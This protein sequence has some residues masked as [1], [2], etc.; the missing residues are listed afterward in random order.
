MLA[1]LYDWLMITSMRIQKR[2]CVNKVLLLFHVL[3]SGRRLWEGNKRKAGN[4]E[5]VP[6]DSNLSLDLTPPAAFRV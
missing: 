5:D 2:L 1:L 6:R 4:E 3:L